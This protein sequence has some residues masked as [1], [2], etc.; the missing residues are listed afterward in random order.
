MPVL[1]TDFLKGLLDPKDRLHDSSKRA[2]GKVQRGEWNL[3]SSSLL[4]LDLLLKH[5]GMEP[6]ERTTIFETL[7]AEIPKE[8]IL[9]LAHSTMSTAALVQSRHK[10]AR[11]FYFDSLHLAVALES[12]GKI[13]STDRY[14]DQVRGI[15]RMPLERV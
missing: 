8:T 1:E 6:E 2:L 15:A 14:F 13:V 7:S 3:A 4:E 5:A 9:G 11:R 10:D 12:D